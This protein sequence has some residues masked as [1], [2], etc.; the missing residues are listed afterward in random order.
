MRLQMVVW[1]TMDGWLLFVHLVLS[2]QCYRAS[3]VIRAS[4]VYIIV[5]SSLV[6]MK[7]APRPH[8]GSH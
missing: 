8:T 1:L 4:T 2:A 5:P 3:T 7:S 6:D